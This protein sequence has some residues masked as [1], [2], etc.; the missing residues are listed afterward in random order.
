[1]PRIISDI[2]DISRDLVGHEVDVIVFLSEMDAM[3]ISSHLPHLESR[4]VYS[5]HF[6]CGSQ[7]TELINQAALTSSTL[8]LCSGAHKDKDMN[9]G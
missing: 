4:A 1:M 5:I 2:L 8:S 9:M 6:I 3:S 7:V